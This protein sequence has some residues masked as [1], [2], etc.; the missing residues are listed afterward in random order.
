[1]GASAEF[2]EMDAPLV[3]EEGLFVALK[4]GIELRSW[5]V[6]NGLLLVAVESSLFSSS[7]SLI[8]TIKGTE[9][10]FAYASFGKKGIGL[11][12]SMSTTG[13]RC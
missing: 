13:V 6:C 3:L 12:R 11:Q 10:R 2:Y 1:M 9:R 8:H 7:S 5:T 4:V